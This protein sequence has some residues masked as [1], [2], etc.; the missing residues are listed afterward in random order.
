MINGIVKVRDGDFG[1]FKS[2]IVSSC[3]GEGNSTQPQTPTP[4]VS[5]SPTPNISASASPAAR[6]STPTIS[7]S[8]A[9][10]SP[11]P[12]ISTS[13]V[14][15]T[16]TQTISANPIPNP[17][18]IKECKDGNLITIEVSLGEKPQD[19]Y[20]DLRD[21]E[22]RDIIVDVRYDV[23]EKTIVRDVCKPAN[24]CYLFQIESKDTSASI[25]IDGKEYATAITGDVTVTEIGNSC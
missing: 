13:L 21:K 10:R 17:I 18:P 6:S 16:P 3:E 22:G 8:P 4:S 15:R 24:M 2:Y 14:T 7:T 9:A 5:L 20:W 23:E 19:L 12:T 25:F 11:T 1:D